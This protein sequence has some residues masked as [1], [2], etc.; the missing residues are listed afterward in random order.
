M[1]KKVNDFIH[2]QNWVYITRGNDMLDRILSTVLSTWMRK[3]QTSPKVILRCYSDSGQRDSHFALVSRL[4]PFYWKTQKNYASVSRLVRDRIF[5]ETLKNF[6]WTP[7]HLNELTRWP[8]KG[9]KSQ[10]TAEAR[11]SVEWN[12]WLSM[13]LRQGTMNTHKNCTM[14]KE[15]YFFYIRTSKFGAEA[16]RSHFF[17]IRL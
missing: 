4:P 13:D 11:P 8:R 12:G 3:W 5:I 9:V 15:E 16:E 1:E 10:I 6:K 2:K 14:L 17:A 7:Q